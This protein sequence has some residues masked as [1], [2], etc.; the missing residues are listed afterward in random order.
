MVREALASRGV[1][2]EV[3]ARLRAEVFRS[4]DNEDNDRL[5]LSNENTFINELVRE[6]LE[7]N[8]YNYAASVLRAG[9]LP[10]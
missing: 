3:R 2:G 7:F 4:L 9:E 5:P 10:V 8:R 6:Y 1:L